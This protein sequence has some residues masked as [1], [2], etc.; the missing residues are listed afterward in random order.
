MLLHGSAVSAYPDG[1][2][3]PQIAQTTAFQYETAEDHER[4]FM[5]RKPG[6]AYT[7]VGNPTVA[8]F[9]R[10]IAELEGGKRAYACSSG[11]SAVALALLNML[12]SG[13]EIIAGAG[14]YGGTI[15]LLRDLGQFG[16]VTR[17]VKNM[18]ADEIEPLM[19][20]RTR[21]LFGEV[22]GNP[23]L[24]V[25]DIRQMAA[26][27]H[28]RGIPLV[29]DSTTATPYLVRP[30]ELGADLVV[31]SS[32]KYINGG[33]NSVSGVIIDAESFAWDFDRFEALAPFKKYGHLA[34]GVRMA[35]DL[36]ENFGA[37]LSP[38]NAFLNIIGMET[39][40]LRMERICEGARLLAESLSRF[41]ELQVRYPLLQGNP[42]RNLAKS[43][44]RGRGGG[45]ITFRAG[46]KQKAFEVM[47]RLRYAKRASNIGDIRTLVIHPASTLYI[48]STEEERGRAGVFEDTVRV[49][50]G[51]EDPGDL[52]SDFT[53]AV[54]SCIGTNNHL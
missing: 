13:D 8:A 50:V 27:A 2:T 46:S 1:A 52:I 20:D 33:G 4:V 42:D 15:D 44:L 12:G 11:M 5:G 24:A 43:Q 28:S 51:I 25:M 17:F 19:N 41:P 3:I 21:V 9:E 6:F 14:L 26:L 47:N 48:H 10:R 34:Y 53:D 35:T 30:I 22:I 32:S 45:I 40:G 16:I 54:K 31:H 18:T 39:L 7:R 36:R 38:F 37:C 49:S 29:V 23:S